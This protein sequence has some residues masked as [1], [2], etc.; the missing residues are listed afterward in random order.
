MCKHDD[1][2]MAEWQ[3][4]QDR[5]DEARHQASLDTQAEAMADIEFDRQY[6]E[7]LVEDDWNS[8]LSVI[9][10]GKFEGEL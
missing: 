4:G 1:K 7:M 2:Q 10:N 3:E 6:E 9:K 5:E 8:L